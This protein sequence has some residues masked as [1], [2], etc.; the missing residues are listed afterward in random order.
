MKIVSWHDWLEKYIPYYEVDKQRCRFLDNP[1]E[2]ILIINP[3]DRVNTNLRNGVNWSNWDTCHNQ[4]I[5]TG[6][7]MTPIFL[8]RDTHGKWYWA[9]W[10]K[11]E[12]LLTVIK[13]S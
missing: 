9:F 1:P 5:D 12:A 7:A 3:I 6:Y 4:I 8:E 2:A 13:L 11:N 10:S